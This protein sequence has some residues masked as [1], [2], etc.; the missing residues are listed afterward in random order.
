[1]QRDPM[2]VCFSNF[3]AL[4]GDAYGYSYDLVSLANHYRNYRRLMAHWHARFPGGVIDVSYPRLVQDTEA[5]AR[6][7]L[8]ACGLPF[9]PACL[10]TRASAAPVA[11]I[12]AAQVREP[13][14]TRTLG[15]W[16]R[17]RAGLAPLEAA[18]ADL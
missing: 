9:D 1:M 7:L 6:D 5:A 18:L 2:D 17:Y 11:T 14:H 8:A 16:Q 12:S 4:F 13:I 15:E 3:R 10:D